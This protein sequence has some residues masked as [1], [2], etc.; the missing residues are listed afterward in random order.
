MSNRQISEPWENSQ[1]C[2]QPT[3][4]KDQERLCVSVKEEMCHVNIAFGL[5]IC[6]IHKNINTYSCYGQRVCL[7]KHSTY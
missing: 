3:I 2:P 4:F 7:G 1:H 5:Q 6:P